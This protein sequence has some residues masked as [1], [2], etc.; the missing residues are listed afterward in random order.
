[1]PFMFRNYYFVLLCFGIISLQA[2]V[3]PVM[4]DVSLAT[5]PLLHL[6]LQDDLVD[7]TGGHTVSLVGGSEQYGQGKS[8]HSTAYVLGGS[9]QLSIQGLSTTGDMTL[10]TYVDIADLNSSTPFIFDSG[11]SAGNIKLYFKD[12]AGG[13]TSASNYD[14]RD[15]SGELLWLGHAC[16]GVL[17]DF[18]VAGGLSQAQFGGVGEI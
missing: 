7:V 14:T 6:P 13:V 1:M 8:L 9:N 5:G 17:G 16:G 11:D 12:N 10:A 2:A 4:R 15:V 18:R 3:N